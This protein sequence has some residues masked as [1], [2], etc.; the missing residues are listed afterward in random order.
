MIC[1]NP[2]TKTRSRWHTIWSVCECVEVCAPVCACA[3]ASSCAG[4]RCDVVA[5]YRLP[6]VFK[7]EKKNI[8]VKKYQEEGRLKNKTEKR[9]QQIQTYRWR[10]FVKI[11]IKK[12]VLLTKTGRKTDERGERQGRNT[13][14]EAIN[15][16]IKPSEKFR[17]R[18]TGRRGVLMCI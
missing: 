18:Q 3:S 4:R 11:F 6:A 17:S 2:L 12:P 16:Q 1:F 8:P 10:L 5:A 7:S 9:W 14:A 13:R 15:R